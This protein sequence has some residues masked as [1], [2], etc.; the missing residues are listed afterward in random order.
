[1]PG[2]DPR[3]VR[4]SVTVRFLD[5]L[6]ETLSTDGSGVEYQ[7]PSCG[8][9]FDTAHERCPECGELEIRERGSFEFGTT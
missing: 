1:M 6:R 7:C 5:R 8:T 4:T 9:V 2:P 3:R